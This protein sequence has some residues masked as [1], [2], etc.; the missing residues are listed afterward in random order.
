M[1]NNDDENVLYLTMMNISVLGNKFPEVMRRLLKRVE[2]ES[3]AQ[4][5]LGNPS[6]ER[7]EEF[8]ALAEMLYYVSNIFNSLVP[9]KIEQ[10]VQSVDELKEIN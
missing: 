1:S 10:K 7:D 4:R 3:S 8:C 9:A 6:I 5:I 2:Q